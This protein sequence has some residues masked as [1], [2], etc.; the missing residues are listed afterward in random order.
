MGKNFE[1]GGNAIFS[2]TARNLPSATQKNTQKTSAR[3]A[4]NLS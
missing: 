1:V 3:V 2:C 4:G